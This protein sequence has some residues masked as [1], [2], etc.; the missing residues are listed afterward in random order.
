MGVPFI[1]RNY[2]GLVA[3]R[4]LERA[5]ALLWNLRRSR[6]RMK[7]FIAMHLRGEK[8][9]QRTVEDFGPFRMQLRLSDDVQRQIFLSLYESEEIAMC[10]PLVRSGA[11]CIDV[12]AN[13][14]WF[15][16]HFATWVG[17]S[18]RVIA[19]EADPAV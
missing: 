17:P 9:P 6:S 7:P 4:F 3:A 10:R 1:L 5:P 16:L 15:T 19:C 11:T 14:G 2:T 13:V 18:G 12:G 8:L